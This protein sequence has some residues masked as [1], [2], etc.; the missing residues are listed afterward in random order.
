MFCRIPFLQLAPYTPSTRRIHKNSVSPGEVKTARSFTDCVS[1]EWEGCCVSFTGRGSMMELPELYV[2]EAYRD[3]DVKVMDWQTQTSCETKAISDDTQDGY[4]F[5]RICKRLMP[6]VG[7]EADA[8]AFEEDS[9]CLPILTAPGDEFPDIS[10]ENKLLLYSIDDGT[11]ALGPSALSGS[12][13]IRIEHCLPCEYPPRDGTATTTSAIPRRRYR[14]EHELKN[15][16]G[17]KNVASWS[18]KQVNIFCEEHEGDFNGGTQLFACGAGSRKL[19]NK[20]IT[21]IEDFSTDS[22]L[23]PW[24]VTRSAAFGTKR[25]SSDLWS[26]EEYWEQGGE[27]EFVMLPSGGWSRFS[28]DDDAGILTIEAGLLEAEGIDFTILDDPSTAENTPPPPLDCKV[29]R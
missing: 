24:R 17:K 4:T 25:R 29:N 20:R 16:T 3:W 1:G 19:S 11:F 15:W 22:A 13:V 8:V 10:L 6:T 28:V 12:S 27:E 18:L 9:A 2:P 21:Q 14:I 7:C 23:L 5:R 26:W